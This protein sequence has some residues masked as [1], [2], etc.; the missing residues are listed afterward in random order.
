MTEVKHLWDVDHPYY[1]TEGGYFHTQEHFPT[2]HSFGSWA[3]FLSD[4]G[5]SDEDLNLLFRWDWKEQDEDSGEPTFNGDV[6]YRNGELSLF[7]MLQRKGF[8]TTCIV[9]VCR[10]DEPEVRAWLQRRLNYLIGLW[11]PLIPANLEGTND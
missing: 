3:E 6:H 9:Q 1:C 4:M 2:I 11:A 7:F 8:H 10:A 5:S